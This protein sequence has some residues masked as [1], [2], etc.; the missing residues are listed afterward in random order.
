MFHNK[1]ALLLDMNS[2]F[3][4]GEDR[5]GNGEDYSIYYKEIGGCLTRNEI[6]III[7]NV[8]SYLGERY[9]DI[10]YRNRF[11]SVADAINEVSGAALPVLETNKIIDTFAYHE[12]GYIPADYL[13]ALFKLKTKYVLAAVI[14]IWAPK[15]MWMETFKNNGLDKLFSALSFSS[16]HGIV[17]PSAKPFELVVNKLGIEKEKCLVIGDSVRR[18][19]GSAKLAGIDCILVGGDCNDYAL[20]HYSSLLDFSEVA[21]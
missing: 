7:T 9:P 16:D 2:T 21:T 19:L 13:K 18:D 3:M 20:A 6:N 11:P 17:K 1:Q 15:R 14:D 12:H 8:L 4:F 10:E 5:F